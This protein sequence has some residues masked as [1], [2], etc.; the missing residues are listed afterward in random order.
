MDLVWFKGIYFIEKSLVVGSEYVVYG[1][2]AFFGTQP[3]IA[4]PE[5]E[6]VTKN[7]TELA[8][9]MDAVY[10]T[11]EKLKGK[12]L[13]PKGIRKVMG[14]LLNQLTEADIPE[15]LPEYVIKKLRFPSRYEALKL[16]H[17]P[18]NNAEMVLGRNRLK[19]EEL[20]MMQIKTIH[21]R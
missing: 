17:Q 9:T 19:F 12:G 6:V 15:N 16:V 10:P 11:T 21:Q 13:D 2:P 18:K 4:H 3:N 14:I 8:P 7:N 5:I 20:F 1:K